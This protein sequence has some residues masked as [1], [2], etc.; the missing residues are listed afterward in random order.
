MERQ[1][2]RTRSAP[3]SVAAAL[4]GR[5]L[6]GAVGTALLVG[7]LVSANTWAAPRATAQRLPLVG[8]LSEGFGPSPLNAAFWDEMRSLG[9]VEGETIRVETRYAQQSARHIHE[10]ASELVA[11]QPDAL[12]GARS[13]EA[14]GPLVL[15]KTTPIVVAASTDPVGLRLVES[16]ERPG[17]QI[18]GL[19]ALSPEYAA[20]RLRLLQA[21]VPGLSRVGI[22]WDA[23]DRER[24]LELRQLQDAARTL[25]VELVLQDVRGESDYARAFDA[26]ASGGAQ[27]L[28]LLGSLQV[29]WARPQVM[30]VAAGYPLPLMAG[31]QPFVADGALLAYTPRQEPLFRRAAHYMDRVLRGAN[32]AE[33]PMEGP[34]EFDLVLN[35][36]T[37]QA[38]GLTIPQTVLQQATEII[39]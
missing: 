9:W 18:T 1:P 23:F 14:A 25:G 27:A 6:A 35:L 37:A 2:E 39:Q 7:A 36:K 4:P 24:P 12:F 8:Y 3:W 29:N 21:I 20:A 34:R 38:L 16:L 5:V 28:I 22:L 26:A 32:P 33:M 11:L 17:G 15:T 31:A 13:Y 10:V 30:A 19:Y